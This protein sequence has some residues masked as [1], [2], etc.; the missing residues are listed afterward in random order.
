MHYLISSNQ[1]DKMLR[2]WYIYIYL[3]ANFDVLWFH[4]IYRVKLQQKLLIFELFISKCWSEF[5]VKLF[6]WGKM[7]GTQNFSSKNSLFYFLIASEIEL[8]DSH[9]NC[10]KETWITFYLQ[11]WSR[12]SFVSLNYIAEIYL[13]YAKSVK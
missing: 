11:K 13:P 4:E 10:D 12:D 1:A 8:C 9:V 6:L 7:S 3:C 5:S 2:L